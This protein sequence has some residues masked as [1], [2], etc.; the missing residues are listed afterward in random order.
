MSQD[1]LLALLVD[2]DDDVL[3]ILD[4]TLKRIGFDTILANDGEEGWNLFC[5]RHPKLVISDVSMPNKDG[6]QLLTDIKSLNHETIVILISGYLEESI[7][8]GSATDRPDA[9]LMK[10]FRFKLLKETIEKLF[11]EVSS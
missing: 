3:S 4:T 8:I 7:S 9:V 10:P 6:L 5:D 2:D 11:P 1:K